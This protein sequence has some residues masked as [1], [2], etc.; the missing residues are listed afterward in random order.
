M[1]RLGVRRAGFYIALC[2]AAV[3]DLQ[4]KG[5]GQHGHVV[6]QA[7]HFLAV[8]EG[9]DILLFQ[10]L[11]FQAVDPGSAGTEFALFHKPLADF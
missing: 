5:H 6:I 9:V 2:R 3:V 4:F 7:G 10:K 11:E 1:E 8:G